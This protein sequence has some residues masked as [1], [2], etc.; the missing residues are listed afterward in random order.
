[1]NSESMPS[2]IRAQGEAIEKDILW[3]EITVGLACWLGIVGLIFIIRCSRVDQ[4]HTMQ[5]L[6]H[7]IFQAEQWG[8]VLN[9]QP[10]LLLGSTHL[11]ESKIRLS[12]LLI[13]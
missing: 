9:R 1:M 12:Q 5:R 4:S 13:V 11:K 10:L 6:L 7:L 2:D 8:G 3:I